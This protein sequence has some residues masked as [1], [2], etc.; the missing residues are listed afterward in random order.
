[1][2]VLL[3]AGVLSAVHLLV[4][5]LPFLDAR[6][7]IWKSTAGGI[8]IS[9][10]FLVLLPKLASAQVVLRAAADGGVY[11]FLEHHAYLVA[12]A[13]LSL[14]YGL[15]IAAEDVLRRRGWPAVAR[16]LVVIQAA[17]FSG[18]FFLVGYLVGE[19]PGWSP[20][21]LGLSVAM[22]V[23]FL[24]IDHG[25]RHKYG[26]LYDR[27]LRWVFMLTTMAGAL[28]ATTT[29]IRLTTLALLNSLFAGMLII[30]TIQEKVPS[31]RHALFGPF[32][33]GAIGFGVLLALAGLV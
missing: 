17:G 21:L 10:A 22:L 24:A 8:G 19:L 29:E 3:A 23:H 27:V 2:T 13:G 1:M 9:Y 18:Y 4:G 31:S 14:Y 11:G 30:A 20:G 26:G 28:L 33:A 32:F 5:R 7:A 25:L 12:L 15:D 6:S 16:L